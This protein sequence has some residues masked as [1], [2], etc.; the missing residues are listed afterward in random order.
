[1]VLAVA[2]ESRQHKIELCSN[3][4]VLLVKFN[5]ALVPTVPRFIRS[6]PH[7]RYV[8][9]FALSNTAVAEPE[10]SSLLI[11]KT[12]I[13]LDPEPVPSTYSHNLFP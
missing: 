6:I 12:F 11:P 1:M 5:D 7:I 8:R 9:H 3:Q 10:G 2:V 4:Q 13:G